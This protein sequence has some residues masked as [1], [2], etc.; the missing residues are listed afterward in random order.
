M[1]NDG[2]LAISRF[3]LTRVV[4]LLGVV[5]AVALLVSATILPAVYT[6]DAAV[7]SVEQELFDH[8]PLPDELPTAPQITH[9]FD[10]AGEPITELHGPIE[11][12]P[13]PLD[14]ISQWVI[15]AVI[16]TEDVEF[17]DHDGVNHDSIVRAGL[18][19]VQ[20]GGI[21]EGASTITQQLVTMAHLDP[22]PTIERK[23]REIVWAVQLEERLGKDEILE[24]YLNR[25]YLGHGIYGIGTAA[26]YYFSRP[27][28]ELGPAQAALLAGAIRA[29]TAN[30]PIDN[31]EAAATRR[32]IVLRQMVA[33][34][35]MEEHH[36][37]EAIGTGV[38][39]DVR[40]DDPGEPFWED[41]VKRV[42]YDPSVDLQP[43]LQEAVGDSV[44]TRVDALFEGGLR[45]TTTLDRRMHAEAAA[46]VADYVTDPIADPLASLITV[47][48]TSGAVRAMALGPKEFGPCAEDDEP[49]TTTQVN[50]AVPG[51]GGS[52]RQSGSS[53]KPFVSAA[54]IEAGDDFEAAETE[55]TDAANGD[56]AEDENG[57]GVGLDIEYETPSGEEIEGCGW[58]EP[59]EPENFDLEDH[60]VIDMTEAMR[61]STNVYFGKLARDVGVLSVVETAQAHGLAHS[62]NLGDF[63][64]EDCS[65]GLGSAEIFPWEMVA[66]YGVWANDGRYC[67]PYIIER[68]EDRHGEVLYQHEPECHEATD[69]TTAATMRDLLSEPVSS[70]GTAATVG[71]S[72]P[73]A[74][75]KTGTTDDFRDAWF[76]GFAGDHT[77]AAWV[78]FEQPLDHPDG[79]RDLTIAGRYYERVAGGSLPAPMWADYVSHLTEH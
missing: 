33:M 40:E 34:G 52:G 39:L 14:E 71:A 38:V 56:D 61:D 72:V 69:A 12:E 63:G 11:R 50:P 15:A 79:M 77:T 31:P 24:A 70:D 1:D 10:I 20:A 21:A 17:Y 36:A 60:G 3:I 28:S 35:A 13:V 5:I 23:M 78:G 22:E 25:V 47:D 2:A 41:L 48:H 8:P 66:G 67:E 44:E 7:D 43:G 74:F 27:A 19:N 51:I 68:I 45:I 18:R 30:N 29:P 6:A 37:E 57:N 49:C 62:P 26:D 53:F 65:I 32:D 46:T 9:V 58:D 59:W 64:P 76:V 54:A 75:G 73:D 42:V 55:E 4:L 16:A